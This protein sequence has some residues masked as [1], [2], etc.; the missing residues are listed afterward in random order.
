[1][2]TSSAGVRAA[3]FIVCSLLL[4]AHC[5][6]A[7]EPPLKAGEDLTLQKAIQVALKYHPARL[8]A[9]SQA[10]AAEERIGEANSY[11][12]PQVFGDTQ[13]LRATN[14]GIGDTSYLTF[15]GVTR[16]P[17]VG[18]ATNS[19]ETFDN[20]LMN[21]SA[22]QYLFDFGRARGLIDQRRAEADVEQ[23]R[24][25][26]VE[27]GLVFEVTSRYANL[28]AA[29]Q[30]VKVY[31]KAV[32]QRQEHLHE[33]QVKSAAGLKPEIDVYTAQADLAR[34]KMHLVDARNAEATGKVALDNSMGLGP[35][36]PDYQLAEVLTY[37]EI[38]ESLESLLR[39]AFSQRPDLR[40][41][42]DEARAAGAQIQQYRSDYLPT[43]GA[44]AG[45]NAR[46]QDLPA[47]NNFDVGVLITWPIF[48][49][50]LTDHQVAEAKLHQDA[51]RHSIEDIRQRIFLQV[52]SG[53]LDWQASVDRIH[54]AEQ[55]VAASRVELDLAEKR[56]ETGLGNIIELTDAQR[57]FTQDE[58]EYVQAL[59]AFS[60][61]KAALD[62][63]IG[64][65]LPTS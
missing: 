12:L 31:D 39:T 8:A 13:Y 45:Y 16:L 29:Q 48:N 46:G 15:P 50:F 38:S 27:L 20:Y 52:K 11:L 1:M 9:T 28:L 47:S 56:Y 58:A 3:G 30:T 59:A 57:R 33:A 65:G 32:A 18:R 25:R 24:L 7:E 23:A 21:L 2:P 41:L 51:I 43:F 62:R 55:T 40:M 44:T 35:S 42:E 6:R 63:D 10:G 61:A 19:T 49:G 54:R 34:A 22:F 53:F 37:R 5:V 26:L 60:V 64:T 17:S 36:A 14:N 4:S